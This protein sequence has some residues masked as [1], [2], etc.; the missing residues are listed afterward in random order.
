MG[1]WG[2]VGRMRWRGAGWRECEGKRGWFGKGGN[3]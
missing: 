2:L 1:W 3:D